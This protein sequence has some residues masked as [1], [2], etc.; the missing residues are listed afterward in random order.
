MWH[1][2]CGAS[3]S[4]R[5]EGRQD[6]RDKRRCC[7]G[8]TAGAAGAGCRFIAASG[9]KEKAPQAV[10]RLEGNGCWPPISVGNVVQEGSRGPP[11]TAMGVYASL[12]GVGVFDSVTGVVMGVYESS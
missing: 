11:V 7:R 9:G 10:G 2:R 3:F 5:I 1:N 12:W 4:F 8:N 6:L